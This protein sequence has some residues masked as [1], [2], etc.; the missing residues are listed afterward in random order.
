M[1]VYL[2]ILNDLV[3]SFETLP[4]HIHEERLFTRYIC[5]IRDRTVLVPLLY[6]E[7]YGLFRGY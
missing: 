2:C 7:E 5:D 4:T 1:F 3:H 6:V